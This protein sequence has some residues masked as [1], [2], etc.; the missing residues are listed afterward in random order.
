MILSRWQI[1]KFLALVLVLISLF[2]LTRLGFSEDYVRNMI[3]T[4]ARSSLLL[5]I[6]AFT[7]SG[8]HGLFHKAW[9][10]WLVRN[11]R[12]LGVSFALSHFVHLGFL[13]TLAIYFPE[14]MF[15]ELDVTVLMLA[16]LG[17]AFLA[18]MTITSFEKPRRWLGEQKWKMLHVTGMYLLW[19]LFSHTALGAAEHN[20]VYLTMVFILLA[21]LLIRVAGSI[22]RK[23][24]L[25]A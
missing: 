16:S 13:V 25:R 1:L 8:L 11:R 9:T 7:A 19:V 22:K 20:P 3:R 15:E 24:Q 14:R 6:L 18:A 23:K 17:Y 10:E 4:T 5:F 21:A 2:N 12:Y